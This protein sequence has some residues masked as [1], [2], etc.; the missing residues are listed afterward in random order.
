MDIYVARQ[1]IFDSKMRLFGYELLYRES[2]TN[3]YQLQS[4]DR[5][6]TAEL[7]SNS[8]L[9][10]G[11][12]ELIDHTHGFINFPEDFLIQQL[13]RLLPK[14]KIIVEILERVRP[15]PEVIQ[16]CRLL[17]KDGYVLALDDFI[18]DRKGYEA[19]IDLADIIKIEFSRT[20][21]KHQLRLIQK[22][23]G[24][25][26]FLAEKVETTLDYRLAL[27]MGYELFQGYFFSRPVMVNAKEIGYQ[28]TILS[29]MLTELKKPEPDLDKLTAWIKSDIG[30]AYKLL[31][32]AN[33]LQYGSKYP[34]RSVHKAISR[35]GHKEMIQW[36]QIMMIK[37]VERIE[38]AELIKRSLIRG[39]MMELLVVKVDGPAASADAFITGIFSSLD[40]ILNQPMAQ[41]VAKLPLNPEV[42]NA[43]MGYKNQFRNYLDAVIHFEN[44]DWNALRLF[45]ETNHLT[46]GQLMKYYMDAI[47]WERSMRDSDVS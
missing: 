11:F 27:A 32:V 45:T 26:L 42:K 38:N 18:F 6:A 43:L 8:V 30:L 39:K 29:R 14:K 22:Y 17:K 9:V 7:L 25:K 5:E 46:S 2:Q 19:L 10:F 1:P 23:R 13:P 21:I 33:T 37:K 47:K 31:R 12:D 28:V 20:K 41:V 36:I 16:A 3:A 4:S 44:A 34:I 40:Q 24:Q 15:T 35:L